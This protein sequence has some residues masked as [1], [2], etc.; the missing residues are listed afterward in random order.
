MILSAENIVKSFGKKEVLK[1]I[2]FEMKEGELYGIVGENGCGKS[3]LLK[4]II[5]EWKANEG[6]ITVNGSIGY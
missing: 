3:T 4:I 2:T 1:G 6:K 5:G